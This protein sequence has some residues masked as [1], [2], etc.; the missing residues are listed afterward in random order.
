[1]GCFHADKASQRREKT[2]V[3]STEEATGTHMT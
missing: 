1:M 2:G 3:I